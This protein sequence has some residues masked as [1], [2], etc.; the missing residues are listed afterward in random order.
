M[1]L[2][3]DLYEITMANGYWKRG[4]SDFESVFHLF[5]RNT[6]FG[7]G[8]ALAAGL[9]NVIDFVQNYRFDSSDLDYLAT[10]KSQDGYPLIDEKF[11][12]YL[13]D[14]TLDID[15]E[16]VAEGEVVFPNEPLVRVSGPI[17]Q[18]QLLE[19]AL[20]TLINFQTLIATKAARVV[21]AAKGDHVSEFGL[22]RAQGI[23]GAMSASRAAFIGGCSSTSNTLAGKLYGIPVRGTHAH[24]WIMAFENEM[25]AF[26]AYAESMPHQCLFLVDTYDTIQ[27]VKN[28]ITVG[29]W[30]KSQGRKFLGIRL[31]SGDLGRLSIEA[32]KLLDESGFHEAIIV[33]SNELNETVIESL[34]AQ[35]A[36]INL[37]GV[38]THLVTGYTQSALDGVYKLSAVRKNKDHPW[39]NRL[40]LSEKRMKTSNPGILQVKRFVDKE[41]YIGDVVYDGFLGCNGAAV[42]NEG[43]SQSF[44]DFS[45]KD[46]LQPILRKGKLVYK[47]P[48][49]FEIQ[50]YAHQELALFGA[51][52]KQLSDPKCYFVGLESR[53]QDVKSA[54]ADTF[55]T[56]IG[57]E[58]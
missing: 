52:V 22:R 50:R 28:A 42:S 38:G 51:E 10:L 47:P 48:S 46:L 24:S 57:R 25:E 53:L 43:L 41:G 19:S 37:W 27:G 40:K 35:G 3:T 32:R 36:Q 55:E 1:A 33:A 23:D 34:K 13:S 14:L 12:Q 29:K 7:G 21:L 39:E 11:L 54:L 2:L 4:M 45:S 18:C 20:L 8:F 58:N 5:F 17:I 44:S 30:L 16:A 31:D 9:Q 56:G 26:R 15:M 49:L 6:P